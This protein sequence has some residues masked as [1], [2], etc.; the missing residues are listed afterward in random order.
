MV[1]IGKEL[2]LYMDSAKTWFICSNFALCHK[3]VKIA[4]KK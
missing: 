1:I 2:A 4:L 3:K